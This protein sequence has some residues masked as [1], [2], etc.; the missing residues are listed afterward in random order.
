MK[1]LDIIDAINQVEEVLL[2]IRV[3][4]KDAKLAADALHL[5]DSLFLTSLSANEHCS[6]MH[7]I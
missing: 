2:I 3:N 6:T 7:A 5:N 1:S 4:C